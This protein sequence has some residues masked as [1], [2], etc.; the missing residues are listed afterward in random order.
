LEPNLDSG[1]GFFSQAIANDSEAS[2]V[3]EL[4]RCGVSTLVVPDAGHSMAT[5][6]PAGLARVISEALQA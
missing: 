5:D 6:N 4:A 2:Y 3:E 1:G